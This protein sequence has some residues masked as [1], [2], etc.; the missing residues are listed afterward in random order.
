MNMVNITKHALLEMPFYSIDSQ[1]G[2]SFIPLS[3]T[4]DLLDH[5]ITA[6]FG[7]V[8]QDVG[9]SIVENT[10]GSPVGI[11]NAKNV[12]ITFDGYLF[13][14][15]SFLATDGLNLREAGRPVL[16]HFLENIITETFIHDP[17]VLLYGPGWTTWGHWTIE[18]FTRI[19]L[20][21]RLGT[22]S[23]EIKW[24]IPAQCPDFVHFFLKKFGITPDNIIKFEHTKEYLHC[25]SLII[26]TNLTCGMSCHPLMSDYI[27]WLKTK[28]K[29]P[30]LPDITQKIYL[31]RQKLTSTRRII[32]ATE[33]ENIVTDFGYTIFYPE[34]MTIDE[35]IKTYSKSVSI[36][37]EYGSAS[38]NSIFAPRSAFIGC[39]RDNKRS[40]GF[41]Q[42]A[43]CKAAQQ[44]MCYIFGREE[45]NY[46]ESS[47]YINPNDLRDSLVFADQ[48]IKQSLFNLF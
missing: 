32:N 27:V 7:A 47:Y 24:I 4:T 46:P 30:T 33:I 11:Y 16:A 29:L 21:E 37:S 28:L 19:Y 5:E 23:E 43:L 39:L 26:P 12:C 31:S 8:N 10:A 40:V 3:Q 2:H 13:K 38:H 45:I 17:C 22:R 41:I 36:F 44:K 1:L 25:Q 34:K 48:K 6:F 18:F 15:N 42:S 14:N 9:R 35:Q 20:L